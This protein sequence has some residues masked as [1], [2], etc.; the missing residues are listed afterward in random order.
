V[1]RSTLLAGIALTALTCAYTWPLASHVASAVPHDRGDPLLVT[2]ILWWSTKA[3][4]LTRHWWNAPAFYPSTGV[5][6]FSENL[7]SLVPIA[8]PFLAFTS[9]PLLAYNVLFLLSYVLSGLGAYFFGLALTSRRDAA[10]V[11]AIAFAFAPYRLSHL[12][13]LQLLSS[14]WMPVSLAA[15]HLY[16]KNRR[17]AFAILFAGAWLLQALASGYYMFFLS[18]LV[19]LWL[20]WFGIRRL[21]PRQLA[22]VA[23]C[24]IAAAIIMTPLLLGY[25][26][27]H[28]Q[29]GLRRSPVEI[30]YY[31][32]DIAGIVSASRESWLW[33]GLHAVREIEAEMFPGITI[34]LLAGAGLMMAARRGAEHRSALTF[35]SFAA[36]LMWL[37]TLGPR[38]SLL[39]RPLGI[40]GPYALLMYLPGFDEMRVPARLWM[41]AVLCL[42]GVGALTIAQIRSVRLR[43]MAVTV[44]VVGLLLDGWPG[45]F[46]LAAA[47]ARRP[48]VASAA[49]ARLGLPLASNETESM[50]RTIEDGLPTFNGYSGYDAPQHPALRDLLDRR[51]PMILERLASSGPIQIVVEHELDAD[52]SWQRYVEAAG[53]KR[54]DDGAGWSRF[55]LLPRPMPPPFIASGVPVRIAHADANVNVSDINAIID[56]DLKTRWHAREQRGTETVTIDLGVAHTLRALVLCLG[57]YTSQYPRVLAVDASDDGS[58]WVTVWTGRTALIAYDGAIADP[59]AVPLAVPVNARARWLRVRQTAAEA[60]RGWTIVEVRVLE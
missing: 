57:S 54:L 16:L 47:P 34:V 48:R 30:A 56:G 6:G 13:H 32:A 50:F 46:A 28:L 26:V 11:A 33:S 27:I 37:L 19:L 40:S 1:F 59:L 8:A 2:W 41:L 15:L 55:E 35:Y 60:T 36:L 43:Q 25:R 52:G 22:T 3:L 44:A 51:D 21:G 14:Y 45:S 23:V 17:P 10:F 9:T 24:W 7:L 39:G 38:P 12:N 58:R 18:L 42:S 4:P 31:S 49:V 20:A 5:L 53:S 29:Y